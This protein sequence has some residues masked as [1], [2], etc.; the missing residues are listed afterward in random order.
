MRPVALIRPAL[1]SRPRRLLLARLWQA[2]ALARSRR[3]LARLDDHLLRDIGLTRHDAET[4]TRRRDWDA[5][6][7]WRG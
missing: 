3:A 5:P 4:E 2:L 1:Q 7:H 6:Q